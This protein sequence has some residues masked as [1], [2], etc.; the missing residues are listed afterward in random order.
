MAQH[1]SWVSYS[2]SSRIVLA[3][4]LLIAAGAVA[5]AGARLPRPASLPRPGRITTYVLLTVWVVVIF[6]FLSVVSVLTQQAQQ[7]HPGRVRLAG[8]IAPVT[9]TAVAVTFVVII[10]L[11]RAYEWPV[12]LGGAAIGALAAPMIFEFPFDFIVM[13]RI[14]GLSAAHLVLFFVPLFLIEIITLTLLAA[15]PMVRLRRSTFFCFA[16]ILVVF[17][18]WALYGFGYPNTS[19]F[20]SLNVVSKLLAFATALTLFLPQRARAAAAPPVGTKVPHA[21]SGPA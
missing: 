14:T 10:A 13:T 8:P 20:Y 5:G 3:I 2:G 6:T 21:A 9:Y 18:I 7:A 4:I 11:G 19:L 16:S 1:A 17:A 15:S 12:R